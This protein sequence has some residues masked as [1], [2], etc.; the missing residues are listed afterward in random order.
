[1]SQILIIEDEPRIATFIAKGLRQNGHCIT[2]AQDGCE[3]WHLSCQETFDLIL[4]DLGLP[5]Q[6]GLSL[7][8]EMREAG[9]NQPIV[10]LTAYDDPNYRRLSDRY[11]ASDYLMKPFRFQD[12]LHRVEALI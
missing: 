6:D 3:A 9:L 8:K 2:I 12:L 10:I 11:G 4:L 5:H 7:L 1:M